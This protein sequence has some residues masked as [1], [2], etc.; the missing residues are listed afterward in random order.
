MPLEKEANTLN[1]GNRDVNVQRCLIPSMDS[2]AIACPFI[3]IFR[4]AA[5]AATTATDGMP[6][7][8]HKKNAKKKG[9]L[10]L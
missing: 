8:M 4:R 6:R 7:L 1:E 3:I 5:A 9:F 10:R 2:A